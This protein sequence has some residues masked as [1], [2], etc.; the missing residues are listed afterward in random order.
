M[1]AL[2]FSRVSA[3]WAALTAFSTLSPASASRSTILAPPSDLIPPW[4]LTSAIAISAPIFLSW[5]WRAQRPDSGTTSAI[6][7]SSAAG[8]VAGVSSIGAAISTAMTTAS[9]T[10]TFFIDFLL[11]GSSGGVYCT[12]LRI[13]RVALFEEGPHAFGEVG[14]GPHAIAQLLIERFAR[15]RVDGDRRADLLLDRLHGARAVGRDGLGGG[16]RPRHQVGR[17]QHAIDEADPRRLGGVDQLRGEQQLHRVDVAD[18]LH[19][20]DG[21]APERIDR[22][23]DFGQAEARVGRGGPD[24]GRQQQLEAAGHAITVDRRH[25]RLG[26]GPGLQ[27][28]VVHGPRDRRIGGEIAA[29]VGA[30]REGAIA[31]AGE[32]DAATGAA[33][34]ALPQ[35]SE[36]GHHRS[37]H[38]VPARL[39]VDRD[40]DDVRPVLA[41]PERR[42]HRA[43]SSGMTTILPCALRSV[44]SRIASTVRSS[45]RRWVTHGLSWPVAYHCNSSSTVRR[46]L[47]GSCHRK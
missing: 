20:F 35:P 11:P 22:P 40:D 3:R 44:R 33:L 30:R 28:R 36:L 25:D 18:L 15:L 38:R 9:P 42:R 23:A 12:R 13:V 16:E 41:D 43:G 1:P 34:E 27:E 19:E 32:D 31:G 7:K 5:P 29:H 37:C 17:G 6:F 8:A 39:I 2:I 14:T 26:V 10:A 45:G 21:P 4:A 47:S 46:S 24:V